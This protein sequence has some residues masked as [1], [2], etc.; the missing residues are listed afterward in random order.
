MKQ[1][2]TI[3]IGTGQAAGTIVPFLSGEGRTLAV[4]EEGAFGGTC[5][6]VGCTPTKTLVAAAR[7]AHM[8]RRA[9]DFGVVAAEPTIDFAAVRERM[10]RIRRGNSAGME[11]WLDSLCDVYRGRGRFVDDRRVEVN[12]TVLEG[13]RIVI[14]TGTRPRVPDLPGIDRVPWLDNAGLLDLEEL[15]E[16]LVILGGSYIALEF[17][18]I[19][20]RFGSRVTVIQR[21][22]RILSRE[23]EDI[24][25]SCRKVLEREGIDLICGTELDSLALAEEGPQVLYRQGGELKRTTGSQLFIALG[26]LPNSDDLGLEN[27][28][29]ERD[30]RG[31]IRTDQVLR[32]AVP[33]IYALGDVN[34]RGAFTHTSVHDGQIF[35]DHLAGGERKVGDRVPIHSMFTDPPVAR[36]GKSE[37]ELLREGTPL[38]KGVM[39]MSRIG[40]AREKGE[41]DGLVKIL[42]H[43]ETRL[44]LGAMIH[45]VGGDEIINLLAVCMQNGLRSDQL[46]QTVLAHPTVG[47]LLPWVTAGA[48][49]PG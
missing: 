49:P 19:F 24:A 4:I 31:F 22:P 41:T 11:T 27:T 30:E 12:G 40:R 25:D 20:R 16:H 18:Q 9:G 47:E 46:E 36:V 17:A 26:R 38:L 44:I 48:R 39:K 13:K 6:N 10:N 21:S 43:R 29:V 28:G 3:L 14:L 15:P 23:D 7:A 8:V 37:G 32:T 33:H 5:V 45:G 35:L 42:I 2:D 34:G 1:Y